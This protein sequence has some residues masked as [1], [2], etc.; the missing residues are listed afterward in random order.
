MYGSVIGIE[1]ILFV[2]SNLRSVDIDDYS[3][4]LAYLFSQKTFPNTILELKN[5]NS[6]SNALDSLLTYAASIKTSKHKKYI[7]DT[8]PLS[9]YRFEKYVG[10]KIKTYNNIFEW[11]DAIPRF[12]SCLS[13][14]KDLLRLDKITLNI[15]RRLF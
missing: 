4:T 10:D 12:V 11:L 3:S 5:N 7:E 15:S 8:S 9:T 14:K 1:R 2:N 13:T 6:Y